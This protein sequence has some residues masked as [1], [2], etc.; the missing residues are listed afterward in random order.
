[1]I[2]VVTNDKADEI[3]E[4]KEPKGSFITVDIKNQ[5]F[6]GIDNREGEANKEEFGSLVGCVQYLLGGDLEI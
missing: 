4:T 1:M 2:V 5:L 6:V 3:I